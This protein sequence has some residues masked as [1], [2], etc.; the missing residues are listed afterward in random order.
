MYLHCKVYHGRRFRVYGG[1]PPNNW[2]GGR[3]WDC[4]PNICGI[5]KYVE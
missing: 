1:R 4:P 2:S 3:Q 5:C